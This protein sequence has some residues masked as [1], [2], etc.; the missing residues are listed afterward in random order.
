MLYS[1]T[2]LSV[3]PTFGYMSLILNSIETTLYTAMEASDICS[4]AQ[5]YSV[6]V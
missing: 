2:D 1:N 5:F 4:D 6:D 3:Q